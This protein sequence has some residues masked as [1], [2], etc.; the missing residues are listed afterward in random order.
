MNTALNSKDK[1]KYTYTELVVC[2]TVTESLGLD[3]VGFELHKHFFY[4]AIGSCF[5]YRYQY[6]TVY[7]VA[8]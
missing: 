8:D 3:Y 1:V 4:S 5:L 2:I 6:K 7:N